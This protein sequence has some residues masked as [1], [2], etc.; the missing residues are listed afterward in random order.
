MAPATI[1]PG[2]LAAVLWVLIFLQHRPS[3]DRIL[4]A[5]RFSQVDTK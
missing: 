5:K 4:S 3:F 1:R 2:I